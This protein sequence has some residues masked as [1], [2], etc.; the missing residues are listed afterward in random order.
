MSLQAWD[1]TER[2]KAVEERMF[3]QR[4]TPASCCPPS[5]G[6]KRPDGSGKW[7]GG[8]AKEAFGALFCL[9]LAASF[10]TS[11]PRL[12]LLAADHS[13]PLRHAFC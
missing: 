13:S 7:Q 8:Q 1:G 9:L 12:P 4:R 5:A 10:P 3:P 11:S 2:G 6:V